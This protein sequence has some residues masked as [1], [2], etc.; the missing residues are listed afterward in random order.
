MFVLVARGLPAHSTGNFDI[1]KN[2]ASWQNACSDAALMR[3]ES[4]RKAFNMARAD[5]ACQHLVVA[6]SA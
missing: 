5:V 1:R 3:S 2:A 6:A 4:V